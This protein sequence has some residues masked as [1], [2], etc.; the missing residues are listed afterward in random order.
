ML[1]RN[2]RERI[3]HTRLGDELDGTASEHSEALR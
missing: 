3:R 1:L 2:A